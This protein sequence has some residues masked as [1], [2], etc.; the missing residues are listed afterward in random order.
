MQAQETTPRSVRRLQP[1]EPAIV[2]GRQCGPLR[3]LGK[4]KRY[5]VIFFLNEVATL[6]LHPI[7]T[8]M[9]HFLQK[10]YDRPINERYLLI[11]K[12]GEGGFGVVY[13]GT[14]TSVAQL[15]AC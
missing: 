15:L 11:R 12:L 2:Y 6:Q 13:L 8:P 14:L 4:S 1:V 3:M 9:D 10:L 7:P 5:K